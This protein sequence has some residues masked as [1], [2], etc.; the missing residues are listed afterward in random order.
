MSPLLHRL[1]RG[2]LTGTGLQYLP[3]R[4]RGGFNAGARWTL[5][6]WTSYWR[7][8]HEPAVT[9]AVGALGDLCGKTC[10]DLGAHF[11]Y[12]ACG[13]AQRVGP[14]GQ[15]LAVEPFPTSF[16]RLERHRRMN[17]FAWMR[18]VCAAASDA[19][20]DAELIADTREGDTG[21][22]LAYD[23][24]ERPAAGVPLLRIR[25][26]KLDDLVAR[27]EVRAPHV[28]KIDVEGHGH[29]ALAGAA[30]TLRRARP[31]ILMAFHSPAETA[32]TR[33]LLDPLGYAWEPLQRGPDG[34]TEGADYLLRPA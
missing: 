14:D 21:V 27:G 9:R 31:V 17:R 10:W 13:F 30:A 11:G 28:L 26:V 29:V 33:A 18:C 3:I 7:G 25:T 16:A 8:A 12:Y 5:Y 15:V 4:A 6:P 19:N 34:A 2:V 22:H 24:N 20:G 32:G 23:A 1:A